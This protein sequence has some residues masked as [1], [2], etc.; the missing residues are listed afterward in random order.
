MP[1]F[2]KYPPL[3]VPA[4]KI[5]LICAG[6]PR[7]VTEQD[8][9]TE[10]RSPDGERQWKVPCMLGVTGEQG[11][12]EIVQ[13]TV[14]GEEQPHLEF[15][16]RLEAGDLVVLFWGMERNGETYAG[17]SFRAGR[18]ASPTQR[19]QPTTTAPAA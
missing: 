3:P 5:K 17:L 16:E 2:P 15:G 10:R 11:R 1:V 12:S 8:R 6:E 4:E 7:L 18:L 9:V 19:R 14:C 13:V